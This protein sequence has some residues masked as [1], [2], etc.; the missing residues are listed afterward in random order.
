MGDAQMGT[1][2]VKSAPRVPTHWEEQMRKAPV[3]K[4]RVLQRWVS[5][6]SGVAEG[7]VAIKMAWMVLAR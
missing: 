3:G 4:R 7:W 1:S 2:D 5:N 6:R